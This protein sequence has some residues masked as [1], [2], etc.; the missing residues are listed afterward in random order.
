MRSLQKNGV[1]V[2]SNIPDKN[3]LYFSVIQNYCIKK[4][5]TIYLKSFYVSKKHNTM[6][7]F[8]ISPIPS[9]VSLHSSCLL[10]SDFWSSLLLLFFTI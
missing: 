5:I 2:F 9:L 6:C 4:K 10:L 7:S 8:K 1:H 3:C